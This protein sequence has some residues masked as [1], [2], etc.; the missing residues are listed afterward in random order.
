MPDQGGPLPEDCA[1]WPSW[2]DDDPLTGSE[3]RPY[4]LAVLRMSVAG[5]RFWQCRRL[6]EN[7]RLR[8]RVGPLLRTLPLSHSYL[9]EPHGG[10]PCRF[11]EA[12][13]T[14]WKDTDPDHWPNT[15][16]RRFAEEDGPR[17]GLGEV[18]VALRLETR[19]GLVHQVERIV[20]EC[21]VRADGGLLIAQLAHDELPATP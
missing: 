6:I 20:S 12:G 9:Q 7:D 17:Q 18:T 8:T 2:R 1:P 14:M 13:V 10:R 16:Y 15:L 21:N 3:G 4:V 11:S 19:T 5:G